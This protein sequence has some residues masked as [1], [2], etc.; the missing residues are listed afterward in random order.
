MELHLFT[1]IYLGFFRVF[2]CMQ[3]FSRVIP[4]AARLLFQFP[5]L[6]KHFIMRAASLAARLIVSS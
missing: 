4:A 3:K 5:K 2:I 1:L 6:Q